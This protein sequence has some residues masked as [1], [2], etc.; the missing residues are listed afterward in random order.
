MNLS[1]EKFGNISSEDEIRAKEAFEK[2]ATDLEKEWNLSSSLEVSVHL[3][4]NEK[5]REGAKETDPASWR[6]CFLMHDPKDKRVYINV[7]IFSILPNEAASMIK[8]ELAHVVINEIIGDLK[9]KISYRKSY[10]FHE[11]FAGFENAT[12]LL[13]EKIKKEKI[14]SIPD[15]LFIDSMEKIKQLGGD[16]NKEP[17]NRQLGYLV[18]FSFAQFLKEK[19]GVGK[20]IEIY[21]GIN[22]KT[23]FADSYR[24]VCK[25]DLGE[26]SEVW[27]KS[28]IRL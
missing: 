25:G 5:F 7:A 16:S 14:R 10:P 2:A 23:S 18:I 12:R 9:Y 27:K 8:H 15:P 1:F 11:G 17:F 22:D 4:S 20:I 26:V 21:K 3:M 19:H 24:D 6:Y 13:I 28:I